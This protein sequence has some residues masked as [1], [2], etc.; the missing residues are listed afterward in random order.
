MAL[1]MIEIVATEN[2][3]DRN[4]PLAEVQVLQACA[5]TRLAQID[6]FFDSFAATRA[7]EVDAPD[8]K[9]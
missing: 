5:P 4:P 2:H 3:K 1:V 9:V 8:A 7:R 6:S